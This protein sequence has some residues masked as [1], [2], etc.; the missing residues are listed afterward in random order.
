MHCNPLIDGNACNLTVANLRK[1]E[2]MKKK[3][4]AEKKAKVR[5]SWRAG[6][7]YTH[8]FNTGGKGK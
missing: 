3:L 4:T 8:R 1:E 2:I 5:G 7:Q 6:V